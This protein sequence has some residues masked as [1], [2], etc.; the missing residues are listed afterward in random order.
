[1]RYLFINN[2]TG[3]YVW[4]PYVGDNYPSLNL[5]YRK[6]S[7]LVISTYEGVSNSRPHCI[8]DW[9]DF[10]GKRF[11]KIISKD[12]GYY[13]IDKKDKDGFYPHTTISN[14]CSK[15]IPPEEY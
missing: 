15:Y 11:R 14:S 6:N 3:K 9:V 5:I 10:D 4:F 2:K 12:L 7:R 1:V 8:V 13:Y